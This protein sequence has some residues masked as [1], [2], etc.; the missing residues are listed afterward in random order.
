MNLAYWEEQIKA[1]IASAAHIAVPVEY[2]F[3][4]TAIPRS[5]AIVPGGVATYTID[6]KPTGVFTASVGL[7]AVSP[8]PSLTLDLTPAA[9]VPPGQATLTLT[10]TH[11]TA[12]SSGLWYTVPITATGRG[13]TQTASIGLLVKGAPV[14]LPIVLCERLQE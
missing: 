12:I 2:G 4:L 14:Y 7:I 10:D 13:I 1:T 5:R 11:S 6:L 3:A 9:L 8:S